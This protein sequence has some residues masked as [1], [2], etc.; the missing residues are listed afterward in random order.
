MTTTISDVRTLPYSP[1][2]N[3]GVV[4]IIIT[5]GLPTYFQVSGINLDGIV[6]VNWYP[7]NPSSLQFKTRQMILVDDT[8]GTFMIQ[9][10]DN[11]LSTVDRAGFISFRISDDTN[12]VWPVKTYGPVSGGPLWQAPDSGLSTG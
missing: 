2:N 11:Y 1:Y 6:S 5:S 9:V 7:K 12:I 10:T 8:L 4:G 3:T